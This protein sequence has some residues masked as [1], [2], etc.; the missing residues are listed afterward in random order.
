MDCK[1]PVT[2]ALISNTIGASSGLV[3]EVKCEICNLMVSSYVSVLFTFLL[4]EEM[5]D[6]WF[7]A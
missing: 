2:T 5:F 1:S 4:V 7:N 6:C 3:K